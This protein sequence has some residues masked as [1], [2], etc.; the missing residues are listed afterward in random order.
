MLKYSGT[1]VEVYCRIAYI[2]HMNVSGG[3]LTI[4]FIIVLYIMIDLVS[5]FE[6]LED[7]VI[8]R[9]SHDYPQFDI[10]KDDVDVLCKNKEEMSS[11]IDIIIKK[12]YSQFRCRK[13]YIQSKIHL[14][15][16]HN[17]R[18]NHPKCNHTIYKSSCLYSMLK[19]QLFVYFLC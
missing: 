13:T 16:F 10:G 8:V 17:S 18:V 12:M 19:A 6:E 2:S 11:K 14:D 1:S 4:S 7:Y 15:V 5:V 3:Y 9:I